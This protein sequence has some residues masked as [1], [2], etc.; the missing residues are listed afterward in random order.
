[1]SIRFALAP[2]LV[3]ALSAPV[4]PD[5]FPPAA[6]ETAA[7]A[8]RRDGVTGNAVRGVAAVH[9][10]FLEA[11]EVVDV[12]PTAAEYQRGDQLDCTLHAIDGDDTTLVDTDYDASYETGATCLLTAPRSGWYALQVTNER[13]GDYRV[14]AYVV[15]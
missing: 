13:R 8:V 6:A 4:M 14:V 1:M 2:L 7:P 9:N 3:G 11:S 12:R 10:L 15:E 5:A